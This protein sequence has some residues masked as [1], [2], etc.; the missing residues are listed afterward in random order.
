MTNLY[1]ITKN[2]LSIPIFIDDVEIF[3]L[4]LK[5]KA[6]HHFKIFED[7]RKNINQYVCGTDDYTKAVNEWYNKRMIEIVPH[8]CYKIDELFDI[9]GDFNDKIFE[10]I[11]LIEDLETM[12]KKA[13]DFF[14]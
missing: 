6:L 2:H 1:F 3:K 12:K 14:K 11:L 10:S 7:T 4:K 5:E 8:L 13:L 9:K